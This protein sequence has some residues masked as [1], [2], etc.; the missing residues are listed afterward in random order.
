MIQCKEYVV[1]EKS[2]GGVDLHRVMQLYLRGVE[3]HLCNSTTLSRS[4][5]HFREITFILILLTLQLHFD[6]PQC[7]FFVIFIILYSY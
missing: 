2:T 5:R 4:Y 3:V 7:L 1:K 6:L